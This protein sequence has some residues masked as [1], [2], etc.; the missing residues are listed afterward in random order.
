VAAKKVGSH[1]GRLRSA[2]S[3]DG[4]R[5]SARIG[6][7][8]RLGGLPCLKL[9]SLCL[10]SAICAIATSVIPLE[11]AAERIDPNTLAERVRS[12]CAEKWGFAGPIATCIGDKER[13]YGNELAQVYQRAL[14]VAGA[15]APLLRQ[16]QRGWLTFQELNCN[17]HKEMGATEGPS[18]GRSSLKLCELHSTLERLDELRAFI[19]GP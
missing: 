18:F 10:F 12:D 8:P 19:E 15:N 3:P 7:L 4:N 9:F 2:R 1:S 17:F 13:E 11:A 16:S 14:T 6:E 5:L